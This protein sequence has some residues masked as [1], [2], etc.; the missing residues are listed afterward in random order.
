MSNK[1]WWVRSPEQDSD[2]PESE[3]AFD[4]R[5]KYFKEYMREHPEADP[6]DASEYSDRMTGYR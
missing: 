6:E 3:P 4:E 5:D 2:T 1:S